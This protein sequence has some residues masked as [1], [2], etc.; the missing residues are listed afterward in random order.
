MLVWVV[1]SVGAGGTSAVE[2]PESLRIREGL[3]SAC[4]KVGQGRRRGEITRRCLAALGFGDEHIEVITPSLS[5][6]TRS[7]MQ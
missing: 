3:L 2:L 6:R 7:A 4:W 1:I 5:L